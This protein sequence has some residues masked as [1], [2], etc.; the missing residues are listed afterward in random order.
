MRRKR[1]LRIHVSCPHRLELGV[2][3][4]RSNDSHGKHGGLEFGV[5]YPA[6]TERRILTT[7]V[8]AVSGQDCDGHHGGAEQEIEKNREGGEEGKATK[9]ASEKGGEGGIDDCGTG[10]AF[11]SLHPCWYAL[12]V[13]G[14]IWTRS[15]SFRRRYCWWK[16]IQAR[17]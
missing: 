15:A 5:P 8:A 10:H 14:E 12:V 13:F 2:K 3:N 17:K 6:I 7:G 11:D 1:K 4:I 9:K 16:D